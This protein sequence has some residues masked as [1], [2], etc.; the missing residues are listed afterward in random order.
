MNNKSVD[1]HR[2]ALGHNKM[3]SNSNRRS[4]V[5]T[6]GQNEST[7]VYG[8]KNNVDSYGKAGL[9]KLRTVSNA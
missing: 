3:M 4:Q 8:G 7:I 6:T 2:N 1:N 5:V 9:T